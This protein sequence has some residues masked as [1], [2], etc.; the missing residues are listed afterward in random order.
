MTTQTHYAPMRVLG[1]GWTVG[2]LTIGED[3]TM[4]RVDGYSEDMTLATARG[5]SERLEQQK[6][7]QQ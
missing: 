3:R 4:R 6:E 1:A 5:I 7:K 2:L